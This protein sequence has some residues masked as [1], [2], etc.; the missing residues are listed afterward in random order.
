MNTLSFPNPPMAV[1]TPPFAATVSLP[2]LP[3]IRSL[4]L[5]PLTESPPSAESLPPTTVAPAGDAL[6]LMVYPPWLPKNRPAPLAVIESLPK[7]L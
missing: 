7:P 3:K 5:L 4:E 6:T 1:S 2:P